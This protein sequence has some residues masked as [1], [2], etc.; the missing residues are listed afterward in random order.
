LF[1]ST[2][3]QA[4]RDNLVTRLSQLSKIPFNKWTLEQ[5]GYLGGLTESLIARGKKRLGDRIASRRMTTESFSMDIEAELKSMPR[6]KEPSTYGSTEQDEKVAYNGKLRSFWDAF[7]RPSGWI[8][9]KIGDVAYHV[10]IEESLKCKRDKFDRYD[11]RIRPIV[12]YVEKNKV[13]PSMADQ[14]VIEGVGYEGNNLEITRSKL[15]GIRCLVGTRAEFNQKQRDAF[16]YGCLFSPDEKRPGFDGED[17]NLRLKEA[18]EKKLEVILSFLEENMREPDRVI[19]NLMLSSMN[20]EEAFSRFGNA[21][22]HATN[23]EIGQ[24]PFYFSIFRDGVLETGE[25]K[26]ADML[27]QTHFGNQLET[28]MTIDRIT[29]N[30]SHQQPIMY[31]SMKVFFKAT[32]LQEHIAN[33]ADHIQE[34]K[35]IFAQGRNEKLRTKIKSSYGN[36]GLKF[37][38]SYID[39][40]TNPYEFDSKRDGEDALGIFSGAIITAQLGFRLSS[41][42]FQKLT[43]PLPFLSEAPMDLLQVCASEPVRMLKGGINWYTEIEKNSSLLRYRQFDPVVEYLKNLSETGIK[44][45]YK[46]FLEFGMKGLIYADRSSVAMGW[47]AIVR[48]KVREGMKDIDMSLSQDEIDAKIDRLTENARAYA[49]MR[50]MEL[51]PSSDE[52]NRSPIYRNTNSLKQALFRFTQPLNVLW[53]NLVYDM[54]DAVKNRQTERFAGFAASLVLSGIAAGAVRALRGN[55]PEDGDAD[56]WAKWIAWQSTTQITDPIPLFGEV[57]SAMTGRLITGEFQ[58]IYSPETVPI[59]DPIFRTFSAA[60]SG[61][62]KKSIIAAAEGLSVVTGFPFV[63]IKNTAKFLLEER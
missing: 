13:G 4:Y 9:K 55:G 27:K 56:E 42:L 8:R 36:S 6:Y 33:Y 52:E 53:N 47:E 31:D 3:N 20:S 15:I 22:Y 60:A 57:V 34:V 46:R 23:I 25:D 61:D 62:A 43:S 39:A 16:I 54:P 29:I 7:S 10:L 1:G 26:V 2:G 45:A 35:A 49:D 63:A 38:D 40:I 48:K 24:E 41:I 21:V 19:A 14:L 30:P 50:V 32:M 28:G 11:E 18:G 44:G 58:P 5:W 17:V 37:I 51:Q 59:L 12:D